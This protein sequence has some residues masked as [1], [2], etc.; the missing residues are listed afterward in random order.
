[1]TS[2]SEV[3][4]S[5]SPVDDYDSYCYSNARKQTRMSYSCLMIRIAR[6]CCKHWCIRFACKI[7][8]CQYFLG[9]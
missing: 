5:S 9:R 6:L 3:A 7:V 1:M 2:V 8:Y 4:V